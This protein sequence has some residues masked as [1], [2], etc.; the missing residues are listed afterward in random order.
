MLKGDLK[1]RQYVCSG[2]KED[3]RA[4][5]FVCAMG[6][7]SAAIMK[8]Y[9]QTQTDAINDFPPSLINSRGMRNIGR[10]YRA[11]KIYCGKPAHPN[12]VSQPTYYYT[13]YLSFFLHA[14]LNHQKELVP[15]CVVLHYMLSVIYGTNHGNAVTLK[16]G[17]FG[18]ICYL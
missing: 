16:R 15:W 3:G 10:A 1:L 5:S 11:F 14:C 4:G 9:V 8:G 13:K 2:V 12:G 7:T 18:H 6:C 17:F